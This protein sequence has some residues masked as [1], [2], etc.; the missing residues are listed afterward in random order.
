MAAVNILYGVGARDESPEL[1]GIAHL[2]EHLLF[3]GSAHVADFD[4]ELQRAGGMSNAWTSNDFTNFYDVVPAHNIETAFWLESDRMLA[5]SLSDDSIRIQKSVV[6]EEFKQQCLNMPYGDMGH[7]I[8]RLSFKRH[9][10]RWPVIGLNFEHIQSATHQQIQ[11][12][13]Y[14]HYTPANA[15]MAVSGN[16][17]LDK[18]KSLAEKYFGDIPSHGK[19]VRN[20]PQELPDE[21]GETL[22][23]TANVPL[24]AIAL[25]YKMKGYGT[26]QFYAADLLTDL[27]ANG[28]SSRFYRR[29]AMATDSFAAIDAS[30]LGTEDPGL[31]IV[32]ARLNRGGDNDIDHAISL[33]D[34][35]I[36]E[37][38]STEFSER[39][40]TRAVNRMHSA[41]MFSNISYLAKAQVMANAEWHNQHPDKI[42]ENYRELT[43]AKVKMHASDILNR[44][45]RS[46]LIYRNR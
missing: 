2:L 8:R 36:E 25:T 29:L 38:V 39:E 41:S 12:F 18:V 34:Q 14:R 15:V 24:T 3:T 28:R 9:P 5:P 23:T 10:Y 19:V 43:P 1:T 42:I 26:E 16:V 4:S 30:I 11:D 45:R 46:T 13:F 22:E 7:F 33:I 17:S 27:F 32:N 6:I 40:I 44:Q 20:Y 31:L 35:Q 37:A 21:P